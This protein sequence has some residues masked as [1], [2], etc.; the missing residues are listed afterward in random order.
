MPTEY[1]LDTL[2]DSSV[3]ALY[4]IHYL[5]HGQDAARWR[6]WCDERSL[7]LIEDA[8][9][10]WLTWHD[11][12]PVGSHGD[13]AVWCL[14]KSYG[15]PDGA[16]V[17][18]PARLST[19]NVAAG[20]A[21]T[22][23]RHAAWV[24][25]HAA[26]PPSQRSSQPPYDAARDFATGK[27]ST[28]SRVTRWLLPRVVE[29]GVAETARRR[30]YLRL[31][32]A[33]PNLVPHP[34]DALAPGSVPFVFPIAVQDKADVIRRF[35]S[36]GV[37]AVDLWSVPHR[38]LPVDE[39]PSAAWYRRHLTALPVHQGLGDR[40]GRRLAELCHQLLA[41]EEPPARPEPGF[42]P[43]VAGSGTR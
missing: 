5:G 30:N 15:L 17:R 13:L 20:I 18:G 12:L 36:Q 1:E 16:A 23:R 10:A 35:R 42:P 40:L 22:L 6:T 8:A 14:Y 39:H 27:P 41:T 3:R 28:A 25:Q 43:G 2:M 9:Q 38:S 37:R 32:E 34:F 31:L 19:R 4:L 11:G 33:V 24:T 26:P 21:A 29:P 7:V